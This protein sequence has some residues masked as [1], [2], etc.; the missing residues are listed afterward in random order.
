MNKA[1]RLRE[2]FSREG[3]IRIVG[4]HD[5]LTARLVEHN[6]FDGVWAS[7]FEVSASHAVP[8]ANI[9]T[10]T[11]YLEAASIM[12]DAVSIRSLPTA[13]QAMEIQTMWR[14]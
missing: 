1:K 7:G 12:N 10:M 13:T 14:I 5:G 6:G 9:L 2:L 4:A 11:Q 8:D 3:V